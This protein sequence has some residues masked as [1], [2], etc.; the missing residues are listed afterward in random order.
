MIEK[1]K[2][3]G[4]GVMGFIGIETFTLSDLDLTTKIICQIV[5]TVFTCHYIYRKIKKIQK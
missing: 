1:I 4:V 3:I 5:V 2:T